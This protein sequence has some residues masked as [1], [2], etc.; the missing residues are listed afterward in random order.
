MCNSISLEL[1]ESDT[2][3]QLIKKVSKDSTR[4]IPCDLV[5][6]E[7]NFHMHVL[8][9]PP[10]MRMQMQMRKLRGGAFIDA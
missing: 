9:L 3:V 2:G 10:Y 7:G 1:N 6:E 4:T 5:G 8:A